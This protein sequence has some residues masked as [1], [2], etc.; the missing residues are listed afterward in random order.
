MDMFAVYVD[1]LC[2]FFFAKK[3]NFHKIFSS[4]DIF[5]DILFLLHDLLCG[6]PWDHPKKFFVNI[7]LN[8]RV[9]DILEFLFS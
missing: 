6:T 9:R 8:G 2:H 7:L 4:K 1:I 5:Q 3:S